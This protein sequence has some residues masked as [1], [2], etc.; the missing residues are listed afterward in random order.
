M[1][2]WWGAP[3]NEAR[4]A[5]T[6]W[7]T[8]SSELQKLGNE[9]KDEYSGSEFKAFTDNN[10]KS[11]NSINYISTRKLSDEWVTRFN[12]NDEDIDNHYDIGNPIGQGKYGKVYLGASKHNFDNKVAIKV[13]KIRKIKSNFESVMQ[14]IQLL[15]S[16]THPDI[17]KILDIY[18]DSKK[19]YL[20]M[21]HVQGEELFDYII[22]RES[23]DEEEA[24]AIIW[25]LVEIVKY[26]NSKNICHRDLKPENIMIEPKTLKIKL[27][28]FGLS[29]YFDELKE[30]VSPVGTPYYVAP[31]VLDRKYNKEC[32]MWSIGII[33]Y[34]LLS[35][36]PPFKGESLCDIYNEILRFNLVF[37]D[38]EWE[39]VT[40]EGI[41][42][43]KW[44]IEPNIIKRF[45]PDQALEHSWLN[46]K[47]T[48]ISESIESKNPNRIVEIKYEDYKKKTIQVLK[49]I[50]ER[51]NCGKELSRCDDKPSFTTSFHSTETRCPNLN[52]DWWKI[53]SKVSH[54]LELYADANID[55]NEF[56][57]Q[58]FDDCKIVSNEDIC[59]A[60]KNISQNNEDK[61]NNGSVLNTSSATSHDYVSFE[62]RHI[63]TEEKEKSPFRKVRNTIT[64]EN[65]SL[66]KTVLPFT[67]INNSSQ[68][69][70][71]NT[72][73]LKRDKGKKDLLRV[74]K[75][76]YL[77]QGTL[78][79]IWFQSQISQGKNGRGLKESKVW[80]SNVTHY[81]S[82]T[83][84]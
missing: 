73:I 65:S 79:H 66:K 68:G 29:S 13:I 41:D 19:L 60:L 49:G 30:L 33:T 45:N 2:S 1:K 50:M 24:R 54:L 56:L 42:F 80:L 28:D 20:V 10:A 61:E 70:K 21:E 76:R 40:T 81:D 26:L 11:L 51:K 46:D 31:E 78:S 39:D 75:N 12:L 14:E 16:V 58:V 44:L 34:I 43:I 7:T 18:R 55:F 3:N 22:K 48:S 36:S 9:K 83:R 4:G 52:C 59:H 8:F 74:K 6:T 38:E 63:L 37:T 47:V 23:L 5:F 27:L 84:F 62:M 17:V 15:K 72:R 25:Q 53:L 67:L 69:S 32:D 64:E 77:K 57:H 71:E 82:Q 35:G